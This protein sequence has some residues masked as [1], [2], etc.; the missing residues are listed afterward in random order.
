MHWW[1]IVVSSEYLRLGWATCS[2]WVGH[3]WARALR[4]G[5]KHPILS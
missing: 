2:L 4:T 5:V 3:G 1:V